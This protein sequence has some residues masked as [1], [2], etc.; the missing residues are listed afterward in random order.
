M[1]RIYFPPS[2]PN[3]ALLP[4]LFPQKLY[5]LQIMNNTH[6]LHYNSSCHSERKQDEKKTPIK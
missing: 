1:P 5:F 6:A 2:G 4:A 3:N